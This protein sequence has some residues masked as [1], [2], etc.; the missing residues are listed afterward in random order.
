MKHHKNFENLGT[1]Y[2]DIAK[3]LKRQNRNWYSYLKDIVTLYLCKENPVVV[4]NRDLNHRL[5]QKKNV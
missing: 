3:K 5:Q 1:S 2:S 4:D